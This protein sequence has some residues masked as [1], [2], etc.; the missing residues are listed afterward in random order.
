MFWRK[1]DK[2]PK[3][4]FEEDNASQYSQST[5]STNPPS[6]VST[7]EPTSNQSYSEE[8]YSSGGRYGSRKNQDTNEE[9]AR[10]DLFSGAAPS[11]RYNSYNDQ[12]E[13]DAYGSSRFGQQQQEEDQEQ[14]VSGLKQ[15]IRNVKQE[16]LASTRNALQKIHETEQAAANTMNLLGQQSTQIANVDRNLDLSKAY[17]DRA[18]AQA[19]ELKQLNRSIFIPVISNPFTKGSRERKELEARRQ[20]H[21]EHMNEREDIRQFEYES[22]ARVESAQRQAQRGPGSNGGYRRGRSDEDKRRYQFE[23]DEEDDAVEDELDE[24]LDLLGDATSRIKNM[25][26][27]M[28]DELDS[29][30]KHLTKVTEK[31]DPISERLVMTTHKL[32]STK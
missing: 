12:D 6:Y 1:K 30:N 32:N 11:R 20:D 4:P 26:L 24:N 17:S 2:T 28:R 18:A 21:A 5:Q 23:A 19:S 14:E 16:S 10:N 3:N 29:Q 31:V 25:A 15:Q 22:Q 9:S 27:S 13:Q 8:S 7:P